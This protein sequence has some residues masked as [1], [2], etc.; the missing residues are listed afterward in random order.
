MARE[1]VI[2]HYYFH[3]RNGSG[4]I[5]DEEG[6]DLPD[7]AAARAEALR[8]VRSMLSEDVLSGFLDLKGRIDVVEEAGD[9]V[10]SLDFS[11]AVDVRR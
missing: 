10:L 7:R 11:E 6:R 2:P 4:F 3:L 9:P 8:G 1:A 5:E